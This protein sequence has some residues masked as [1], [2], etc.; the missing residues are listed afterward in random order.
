VCI[1]SR[2]DR[3]LSSP[4]R[5]DVGMIGGQA[6]CRFGPLGHGA[7]AG[8]DDVDL[9]GGLSEPVEGLPVGVHLAGRR[10]SSSAIN[11]S[12][13]MSPASR[14]PR[15]ASRSAAWPRACA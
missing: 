10:A 15:S 14:T 5:V 11:T 13:S 9:P 3:F 7:V 1:E 4:R 8:D 2:V 6:G 12:E